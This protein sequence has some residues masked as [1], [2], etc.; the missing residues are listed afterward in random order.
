M[1]IANIFLNILFIPVWGV[2]GAAVAT[3][4]VRITAFLTAYYYAQKNYKI[5]YE[6]RKV[7]TVLLVGFFLIYIST[8]LNQFSLSIKLVSKSFLILVFPAILYFLNFFEPIE[9]QSLK[10]GIQDFRKLLFS[11]NK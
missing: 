10:R 1:S 11:R 8:F 9:I 3:L 4:I 2:M 6:V 7:I 5:P